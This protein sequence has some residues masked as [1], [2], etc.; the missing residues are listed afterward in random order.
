VHKGAPATVSVVAY[1]DKVF[2][3][4]VD[5]VSGALD[6]NTRSAKVRLSFDNPEKL[7]RPMMYATVQISVEQQ[8]ALAIP[9]KAV[10]RLGDKTAVFIQIGEQQGILKF[11]RVNV[12]VDEG[13][14]SPWLVVKGG[15]EPGTKV[16][17]QGAVL[18]S[19]GL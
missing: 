7:L 3:G 8:N 17:V 15:V 19:Q 5:W 13:E 12:D 4:S 6:P 1:P 18:L 14:S 10:L 16:V 9:R 11:K 2:T